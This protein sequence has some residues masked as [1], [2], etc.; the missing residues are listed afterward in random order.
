MKLGLELVTGPPC[1]LRL[2]TFFE[3]WVTTPG[4]TVR[5]SLGRDEYHLDLYLQCGRRLAATG[6]THVCQVDLEDAGLGPNQARPA[7]QVDAE[8]EPGTPVIWGIRTNLFLTLP[9]LTEGATGLLL[10]DAA[11]PLPF[12]LDDKL[13]VV[14]APAPGRYIVDISA[15]LLP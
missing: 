6:R 11:E 15:F 12:R 10:R 8:I 9:A 7:V 2:G 4:G 14:E 5:R 13:L 3:T 1:A